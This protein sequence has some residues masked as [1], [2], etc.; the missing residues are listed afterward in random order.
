VLDY[1]PANHRL[2]ALEVF[3]QVTLFTL[4]AQS[5]QTERQRKLES[6]DITWFI[7]CLGLLNILTFLPEYNYSGFHCLFGMTI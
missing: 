4:K 1:D 5:V 7:Q 2:D 6:P 3:L